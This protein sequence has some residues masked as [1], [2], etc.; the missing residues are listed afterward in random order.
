MGQYVAS[1]SNKTGIGNKSSIFPRI[2]FERR[3][4]R[5]W[6]ASLSMIVKKF[7]IFSVFAPCSSYKKNTYKKKSV[8]TGLFPP[9]STTLITLVR[10]MEK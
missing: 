1:G 4:S 6:W 9:S 5:L 3:N 10:L 7:F 8:Y 2:T